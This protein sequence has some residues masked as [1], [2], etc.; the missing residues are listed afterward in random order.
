MCLSRDSSG[1][2]KRVCMGVLGFMDSLLSIFIF[3]PLVVGYWRGCWQLMDHYLL[4]NNKL[5]SIMTSLSIGLFSGLFFCLLQ[6]PLARLCDN[7]RRPRLHLFVSRMY[8]MIYCVCCV[9]HW[10]GVWATWDFY[11]GISWQSGA[12]S[13]GI[14]LLTLAVTRGLKNILAPPFLVVTDHP[15]KYFKVPTLFNAKRERCG[16]F[17]LDTV[18]TVVVTGSLVVFVWRGSWVFLDAMLFPDHA[19][20]SAW[21]SMVLGMTVTMLVFAAQLLIIPC[22]KKIRKG[23]GK[24]VIEDAYHTICFI[25]DINMWRGVWGLLNIYLLPDMPVVSNFITSI[26]GMVILMCFYNGNSILVRGAVMDGAEDGYKGIVFPTH[27]LRQFYKN[28]NRNDPL[29]TD[30]WARDED[31][32]SPMHISAPLEATI[33]SKANGVCDGRSFTDGFNDAYRSAYDGDDGR[34]SRPTSSFLNP[35]AVTSAARISMARN[36]LDSSDLDARSHQTETPL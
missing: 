31:V 19:I 12:T 32:R 7:D 13:V 20:Y 30:Y 1:R 35:D 23:L 17:L 36:R 10:R 33:T 6:G 34:T 3:A 21:G 8:T 26:G 4:P 18:F 2:G 27:Y 11:T 15:E 5:I 24:I 22:F 28:N 9:N 25:G 14:G 16:Y 29:R